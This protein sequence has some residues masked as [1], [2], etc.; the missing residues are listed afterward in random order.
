VEVAGYSL[1]PIVPK[2]LADPMTDAPRSN[3]QAAEKRSLHVFD[4]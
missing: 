2:F 4:V 1:A 3:M